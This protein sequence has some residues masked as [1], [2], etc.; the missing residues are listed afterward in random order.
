MV[1]PLPPE[2]DRVCRENSLLHRAQLTGLEYNDSKGLYL[3]CLIG[4]DNH[5]R[6]GEVSRGRSSS[7]DYAMPVD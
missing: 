1:L 7:V 5:T 3:Y 2:N 6:F 4:W